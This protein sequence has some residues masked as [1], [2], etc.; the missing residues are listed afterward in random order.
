[1]RAGEGTYHRDGYRSWLSGFWVVLDD[2]AEGSYQ[3]YTSTISCTLLYDLVHYYNIH[4]ILT[5]IYLT[6]AT[7]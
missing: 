4:I 1:M 2:K 5:S 6:R 3:G 7:Q